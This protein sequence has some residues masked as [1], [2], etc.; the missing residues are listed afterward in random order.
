MAVRIVESDRNL[1]SIVTRRS[2]LPPPGDRADP[3]WLRSW[4]YLFRLYAP[5]MSRYVRSVLSR[6][7]NRSVDIDEATDV[8]HAYFAACLEMG[9]LDSERHD[10]RCFRAFL[11][12]QLK[13]F[14]YGHL[15][16]EFAK[17][18][19]PPGAVSH[20]A[21]DG[22]RGAEPD[23]AEVELDRGWVEVA[24]ELAT[25]ELRE[26]NADYHEVIL[27][28]LRT[29][30]EGSEDLP[31]RMGRTPR[32][33]KNL[34]HRAR[35]RFALLVHEHLRQSVVDEEAFEALCERLDAYLP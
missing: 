19:R 15:E 22:V 2:L 18:R 21:L 27:D 14:A 10:I 1:R 5:A 30:G 35:R 33:M 9:W 23:P 32:Q 16:R 31:E 24:V 34:R 12:T 29:E 17:K 25:E 8:V 6:A 28:L 4:D 13:R 11:Q 20:E 3:R 26:A 7:L